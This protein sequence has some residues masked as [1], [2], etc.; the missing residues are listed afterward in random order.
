MNK[1]LERQIKRFFPDEWKEH[2]A[3]AKFFLAINDSY[4]SFERDHEISER[5]F[6]ISEEEYKQINEKLSNEIQLKKLSIQRLKKTISSISVNILEEDSD[7]LLDIIQYLQEEVEKRKLVEKNLLTT[8]NRLSSLILNIQAGILLE[9]ENRDIILTNQQ[10][11]DMFQIPAPPEFLTGMNCK[12]S[13]EQSKHLFKDPEKFVLGIMKLIT[14]KKLSVNEEIE[15][16]DGKVF[17]RDY[18]PVFLGEDYK[19]HLW[20]Y[21]DITEQKQAQ[22]KLRSSEE[23]WQ[24]ALEGSGDGVWEY[25]FQTHQIYFSSQYKRMLGYDDVSF[26][27]EEQEWKNKIHPDD[28][29]IIEETDQLYFNKKIHSHV[30]EY[31]MKHKNGN[32]IWILDRGKVV[33]YTDQNAPL[34]IIGTHTDITER[35][36]AEQAL[37]I[38]EEKYRN[39]ITNMNLGLLEVSNDEIIQYANNSFCEM[40]GYELDELMGK[41][42]TA[43]FVKGENLEDIESKNELRSKGISD[44]YELAVKDKRGNVRWWLVSGAPRFNDAGDIVGSIG[45][46]LDITTQK[47]LEIDLHDARDAA[48]QS[49]E[50]QENFLANMSHEIRTPMN[51]IIGMANQLQ[52][53]E[54]SKEQR[55]YLSVISKAAD[56]L[57]IVIN[58]ILDIS[59]IEAGMLKLENIAFYPED[60][61]SNCMQVMMYKAEEK[62]LLFE[63]Q[64]EGEKDL[65]L[66]GDPY[67]ITQILLNLISNAIKFTEKGIVKISY[68]FTTPVKGYRKMILIVEDT[69]I[70]MDEEYLS[71]L[72]IKFTQEDTTV[73][74]KFGGT[75]LGMSISKQLVEIMDGTIEV[76][77]KKNEGTKVTIHIPLPLGSKEDI[78]DKSDR[79]LDASLLRSR[80]I[81][82]VEDN[83]MNRL[84]A[85][86]VLKK[87]DVIIKEVENGEEALKELQLHPDYYDV[88]LMDVQMPV[89]NGLEATSKIRNELK[90]DIPI[91]A[92]TANAIKGENEKCFQ[93]GMND[94]ISKPFEEADLINTIAKWIHQKAKPDRVVPKQIE[95]S[96]ALYNLAQ[97]ENISAGNVAFIQKMIDLFMASLPKELAVLNQAF[98]EKDFVTLKKV[99]HKIKPSIDNMGILSLH[100]VVREIEMY[101]PEIAD[102]DKLENNVSLL[103]S[104]IKKVIQQ[105]NQR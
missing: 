16:Q 13:A 104:T 91:I 82:L 80:K 47:Q 101:Q 6:R 33:T 67:R 50:A 45:I 37:R 53:S 29:R 96:D 10:F 30:R 89:M 56:H 73:A 57:L 5:S 46:H 32:Y 55:F 98:Q 1:L 15:L 77:S 54:L 44:A 105:L 18:I 9:D 83:E 39:I 49:L 97:L 60:V 85:G 81:L 43:L 99:A 63:K 74:R 103:D 22:E 34:R 62:G 102:V 40:S 4:N 93:H 12:D 65:V 19:G 71:S 14:E 11:C 26:T 23:L 48:E 3:F 64:F 52:K 58:D 69:G 17:L 27:N 25:N 28:C 21:I 88:I 41:N 90:L 66:L 95:V 51:A 92:L 24:F 79:V 38:N 36:L 70:G 2:D 100:S 8:S 72:F 86:V 75:G 31:R 20:K 68:R 84:V 42:A 35:K 7:D 87:F 59:K 76:Q 61:I 94:Y 78:P